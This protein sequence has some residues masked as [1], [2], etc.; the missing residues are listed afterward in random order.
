MKMAAAEAL[1]L[2]S[3]DI[4]WD[5]LTDAG[6]Y[7]VWGSGLANIEGQIRD[8]AVI[9]V[10]IQGP[11]KNSRRLLVC[12]MSTDRMTWTWSM[13]LGLLTVVRT[14]IISNH[15]G[16]TRMSVQDTARGPLVPIVRQRLG[17]TYPVS[18]FVDEVKFRSELLSFH[19]KGGLFPSEDTP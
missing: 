13:P 16:F 18:R 6:N 4:V 11:G 5:V 1:I 15:G 9:R 8:G 19:L 17:A 10:R 14:F 2:A 7:P 12:S 3:S